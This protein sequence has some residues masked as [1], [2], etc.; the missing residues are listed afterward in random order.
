MGKALG[1]TTTIDEAEWPVADQQAM[2][3]ESVV[4]V[5]Q[6]NGKVRAKINVAAE[7]TQEQVQ[8]LAAEDHLVAKYLDGATIRKAI[9]VPGKLLNLVIG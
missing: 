2:V 4:M 7:A 9:F 8:A 1:Q 6:I 5:I 3:E